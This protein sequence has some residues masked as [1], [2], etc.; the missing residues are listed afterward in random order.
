ML[1]FI[2]NFGNMPVAAYSGLERKLEAG[3]WNLKVGSLMV[4][5]WK[6]KVGVGKIFF[7]SLFGSGIFSIN[8]SSP[9]YSRLDRP[10]VAPVLRTK[11]G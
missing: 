7:G 10:V 11:G 4:R 5:S 1:F 2:K 3:S 9:A 8:F 6:L